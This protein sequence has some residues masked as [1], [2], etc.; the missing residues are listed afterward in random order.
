[1]PRVTSK[2]WFGPKKYLGWGW[3]PSSWEGWAAT[4]LFVVLAIAALSALSGAAKYIAF[5]AV[6]AVFG[7]VLVLTGD[8]P[9]GP[10]S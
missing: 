5:V 4:A 1:M 2:A 6:L 10:H 7:V 9:G 3:A 8:P